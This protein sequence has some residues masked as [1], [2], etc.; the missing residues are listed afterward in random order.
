MRYAAF[1]VAVIVAGAAPALS[2][3]NKTTS[4]PSTVH[5]AL[6]VNPGL[7]EVTVTPKMSG[8]MPISDEEMAKIPAERRAKMMAMMQSMMAKPHKMR[9]CMTQAKIDKGF[10]VGRDNADCTS[11]VVSNTANA[12]EVQAKC[13]GERDGGAQTVDVKFMASSP[14][15]VTGMTHVVAERRGKSMTIDSVVS[16]HWL[17][18]N[19]GNVKDVEMEQ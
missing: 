1:A 4:G 3:T 2:A 7:W 16:G 5:S 13:S 10:T 12:M 8:Q 11:T 17:G 6:H 9:E 15:S 18:A 14:T 19:C